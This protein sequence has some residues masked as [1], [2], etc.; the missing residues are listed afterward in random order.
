MYLTKED[1]ERIAMGL[2]LYK[3]SLNLTPLQKNDLFDYNVIEFD[4]TDSL[5]ER[6]GFDKEYYDFV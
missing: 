3:Q 5:A 4:E 6:L 2:M 1:K